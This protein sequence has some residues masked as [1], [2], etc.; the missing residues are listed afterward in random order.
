MGGVGELV[1]DK[2]LSRIPVFVNRCYVMRILI[3]DEAFL[4][5]FFTRA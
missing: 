2:K 3:G 5:S 4:S 1:A